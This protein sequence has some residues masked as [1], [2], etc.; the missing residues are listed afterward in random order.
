MLFGRLGW[1]G[2]SFSGLPHG[3][4]CALN[5]SREAGTEIEITCRVRGL[6]A[7]DLE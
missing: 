2:G 4:D 7:D 6:M 1:D 3:V 5:P